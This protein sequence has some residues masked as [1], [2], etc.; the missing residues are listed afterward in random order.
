MATLFQCRGPVPL[1]LISPTLSEE[2][3]K[4][5]DS[6]QKVQVERTSGHTYLLRFHLELRGERP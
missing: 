5:G 1:Y 6:I 2:I 3:R 4:Y